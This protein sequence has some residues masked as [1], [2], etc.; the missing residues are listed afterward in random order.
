MKNKDVDQIKN[1][2]AIL[3]LYNINNKNN[4]LRKLLCQNTYF[5]ILEKKWARAILNETLK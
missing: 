1:L 3:E 2:Q 5:Q 4:I